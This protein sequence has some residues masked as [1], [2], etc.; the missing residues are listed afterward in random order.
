MKN[1]DYEGLI[2]G[3]LMCH[4]CRNKITSD[5]EEQRVMCMYNLDPRDCRAFDDTRGD[6]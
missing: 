2:D 3:V 6:N 5:D 4:Y 1:P